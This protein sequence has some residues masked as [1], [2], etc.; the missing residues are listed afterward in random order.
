MSDEPDNED[1]VDKEVNNESSG[2]NEQANSEDTSNEIE[3]ELESKNRE[4]SDLKEQRKKLKKAIS[5]RNKMI[6][7]HKEKAERNK[8]NTEREMVRD[9]AKNM[10]KVRQSILL[11]LD[12]AEDDCSVKPGLNATLD[13]IDSILSD[14]EVKV[15]EPERGN[16]FNPDLHEAIGTEELEELDEGVVVE[17]YKQ[18]FAH[19]GTIIEPAK[20]VISD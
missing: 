15:L 18:G 14:Y 5:K 1:T 8:Q 4:I 9:F 7:Q 20:V 3:K 6:E 13:K 17:T 10:G 16:K 19:N 2:N 11:A 12:N